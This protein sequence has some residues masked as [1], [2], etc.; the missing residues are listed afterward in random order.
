MSCLFSPYLEME[1]S[2][3]EFLLNVCCGN[4]YIAG[5]EYID[6]VSIRYIILSYSFEIFLNKEKVVLYTTKM[7]FFDSIFLL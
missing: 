5:L 6:I 7:L 1:E 4:I 2:L 3:T